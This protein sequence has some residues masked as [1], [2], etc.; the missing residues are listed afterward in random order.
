MPSVV[1]RTA[2]A[3]TSGQGRKVERMKIG[4]SVVSF[5]ALGVALALSLPVAVSQQDE[6]AKGKVSVWSGV[7]TPAQSKRGE[8]VHSSS[9]ARC[10]GPKL[11]G[12]GQPD[13]PS[14]PGIAGAI[15]LHKWSGK[16]VAELFVYVHKEMPTDNPGTLKEQESIDS[17]AHMFAVSE[18]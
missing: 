2:R 11:D 12:A 9:C 5:F 17:I 6:G 13:M 4:V 3:S 1:K 18:M 16:T 10:H 7:Y 8:T 14:S 15:L